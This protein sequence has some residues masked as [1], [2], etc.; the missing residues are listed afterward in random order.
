MQLAGSRQL[1]DVVGKGKVSIKD[2]SK[3][4]GGL[5][6][7]NNTQRRWVTIKKEII[8]VNSNKD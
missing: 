5:E 6:T 7:C 4:A 2:K 8:N 1:G 3:V